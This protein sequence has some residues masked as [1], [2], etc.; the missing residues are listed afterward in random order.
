MVKSMKTMHVRKSLPATPST[1]VLGG[2]PLGSVESR[3]AARLLLISLRAEQAES[4]A[5][6]FGNLNSF[7][8]AVSDGHSGLERVW[9]IRLAR[10]AEERAEIFG[11]ALPRAEE[12][13]HCREVTQIANELAEWCLPEIAFSNPAEANRFRAMAEAIL[14]SK[15]SKSPTGGAPEHGLQAE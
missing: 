2:F 3:V 5:A 8:L 12:I 7:E 4:D 10:I 14:R 15:T 13:R 1:P 6:E 11:Y 9:L